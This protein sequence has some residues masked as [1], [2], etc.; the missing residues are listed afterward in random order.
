MLK[1]LWPKGDSIDIHAWDFNGNIG[2]SGMRLII[3]GLSLIAATSALAQQPSAA[4]PNERALGQKLF[5]E[6]QSG[7]TC[8]SNL[9]AA[10][11]ELAKAQARIKELEAKMPVE[12]EPPK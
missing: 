8:S 12:K 7:V 10:Q 4:T 11:E 5:Q 2:S 3:I 6:M 1:T 9:I